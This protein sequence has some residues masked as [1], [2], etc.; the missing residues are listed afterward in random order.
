MAAPQ[1]STRKAVATTTAPAAIGAYSQAI[2]AGS[3]LFVSGQIPL[4]SATGALV[5]GP[6]EAQ[7]RQA[8]VNVLAVLTAAGANAD[9]VVKLTVFLTDLG[10]FATVN[11]VMRELFREPFPARSAV[12]V[13]SL[14]RAALIEVE[15]IAH[16]G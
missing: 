2:Q 11:D 3:L 15:A 9:H 14:P 5:V 1:T 10:H 13:A 16:F 6:V 4:D 12:G 7:I 8:F